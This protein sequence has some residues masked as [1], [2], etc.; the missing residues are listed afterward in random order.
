MF[1]NNLRSTVIYKWFTKCCVSQHSNLTS[2]RA[3]YYSPTSFRADISFVLYVVLQS[4]AHRDDLRN[5]R[6]KQSVVI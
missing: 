3:F 4:T 1:N 2:C 6:Y 5:K